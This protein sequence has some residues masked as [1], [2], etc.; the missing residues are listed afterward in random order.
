MRLVVRIGIVAVLLVALFG[1]CVHYGATYDESWPHPIG[2][3]LQDEYDAYAGEQVLLFGN[4]QAVEGDT[5]IVHVTDSTGELAAELE[6]GGVDEQVDPGGLVQIY[7][8]LEADRTMTPEE[9]VVVD[10]DESA[11][12]YK[13]VASVV[14]IV[15]AIGY[16]FRHWRLSPS[17]LAFEPRD[18]SVLS[19]E[20][21]A[22]RTGEAEPA[23][24]TGDRHG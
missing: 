4:V 6:V 7:G 3:Q 18:R 12:Q 21:P 8:V 14:G 13:L 11:F 17:R 15:L 23:N 2:D 24:R 5:L 19:A 10:R 16:F 22:N 9:T 20:E 1:L